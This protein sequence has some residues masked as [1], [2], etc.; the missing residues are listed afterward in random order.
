MEIPDFFALHG[1]DLTTAAL[2][3]FVVL[4]YMVFQDWRDGKFDRNKNQ[5]PDTGDPILNRFLEGIAKSMQGLQAHYNEETTVRLTELQ[6]EHRDQFSL[7][8]N[9]KETGE[10]NQTKI[11]EILKYGSYVPQPNAQECPWKDV[12][13]EP[14]NVPCSNESFY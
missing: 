1:S 7:L 6:N 12:Q 8:R 10:R 4:G 9:I 13:Y 2:L 14:T 5:I 3:A 11:D